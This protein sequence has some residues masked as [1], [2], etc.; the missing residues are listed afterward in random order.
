MVL[1]DSILL[2]SC[3]LELLNFKFE[4]GGVRREGGDKVKTGEEPGF[5][6]FKTF[7]LVLLVF[8]ILVELVV[9]VVV[10]VVVVEGIFV[11]DPAL[12]ILGIFVVEPVFA[13]YGKL[14]VEPVFAK[15]P[16]MFVVELDFMPFRLFRS[17]PACTYAMKRE[18]GGMEEDEEER[19]K[20]AR[21][22]RGWVGSWGAR[23]VRWFRTCATT[24]RMCVGVTNFCPAIT[25]AA[26]K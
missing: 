26:L 9:V 25:A 5:V 2:L 21:G 13:I 18:G 10:V 22:L 17:R 19:G 24:E 6:W 16:D 8:C 15:T 14:E 20:E 11:V 4:F 23:E 7:K 3:K 1:V 12:G